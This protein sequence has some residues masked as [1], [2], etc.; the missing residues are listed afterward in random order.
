MLNSNANTIFQ[1][2]IKEGLLCCPA[3]FLDGSS[4]AALQ[5]ISSIPFLLLG[6]HSGITQAIEV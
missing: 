6:L 3:Y 5:C 2:E 4:H 1:L